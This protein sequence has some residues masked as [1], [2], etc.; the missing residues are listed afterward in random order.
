MAMRV[1]VT[2]LSL[3]LALATA[4]QA[5][6]PDPVRG[7]RLAVEACSACHQVTMRQ[8]HPTPVGNPD[9]NEFVAAPSFQA[10][11]VKFRHD[12]AGLRAFILAPD[13]PMRE[14]TFVPRDLDDIVAYI[15]ARAR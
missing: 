4:A 12:E 14:Q 10:I 8:T 11:A 15:H 13:H 6:V 3:V 9:T 2:G 5:R 1:L 7:R